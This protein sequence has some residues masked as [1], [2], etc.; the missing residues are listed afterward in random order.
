MSKSDI[1]LLE[2]KVGTLM[3]YLTFSRNGEDL[4]YEEVTYMGFKQGNRTASYEEPGRVRYTEWEQPTFIIS[5]KTKDGKIFRMVVDDNGWLGQR[6]FDT[7]EHY[8]CG[9]T[10]SYFTTS[11]D[12]LKAF[13]KQMK[14]LEKIEERKKEVDRIYST[15]K[16]IYE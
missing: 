16:K 13:V 4:K 3:Y 14:F 1:S 9:W 8:E 5:F 7:E 15:L 10:D 6:G 11:K 12:K 2:T